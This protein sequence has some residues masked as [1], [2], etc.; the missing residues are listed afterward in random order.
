MFSPALHGR[1]IKVVLNNQKIS[2]YSMIFSLTQFLSP[3]QVSPYSNSDALTQ[4]LTF[5]LTNSLTLRH[6]VLLSYLLLLYLVAETTDA[7]SIGKLFYKCSSLIFCFLTYS[8]DNWL[9]K[10][11]LRH[12]FTHLKLHPVFRWKVMLSLTF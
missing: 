7:P 6:S 5:S 11:L 1:Q 8:W 4:S 9:L 12:L 3:T 10:R 2:T